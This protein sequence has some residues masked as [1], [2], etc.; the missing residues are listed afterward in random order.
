MDAPKP[1]A[2]DEIAGLL[3]R[4]DEVCRE[5][6]RVRKGVEHSMKSRPFWPERRRTPRSADSPETIR[7]VKKTE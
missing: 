3:D 5:S 6:E 7:G 2:S 4:I 1:P